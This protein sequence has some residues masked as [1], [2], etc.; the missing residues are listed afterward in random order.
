MLR[1]VARHVLRVGRDFVGNHVQ[2]A[3]RDHRRIDRGVAQIGGQGR[4]RGEVQTI[5]ILLEL[6]PLSEE[7]AVVDQ[8]AVTD[9]DALGHTR[10]T[11][12]VDDIDQVLGRDRGVRIGDRLAG[13]EF[14]HRGQG[15][16]YGRGTSGICASSLASVMSATAPES[17]CA[18]RGLGLS[19]LSAT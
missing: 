18:R 11:R 15:R 7:V 14:A 4:D 9:A 3:A 10:G 5:G 12:S 16:A 17:C 8:I 19:G 2:A 6:Q 1:R 13:P